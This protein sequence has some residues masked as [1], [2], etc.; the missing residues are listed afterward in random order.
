MPQTSVPA[1]MVIGTE[2]ALADLWTEENGVVESGVSEEATAEIAFGLAV[3]RG[4]ADDGV[5][6]LTAITES[7]RGVVVHSH[8]Y[9]KPDEL[10][11]TGLKTKVSLDL[12][13]FGQIWVIAETNVTPAS[14]VFIRAVATGS[15]RAGAF[16]GTA[17]GT[18]TI[19]ASA[20]FSWK[21]TTTA[22]DPALLEV[23][24]IG[25]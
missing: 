4:T 9:S 20:F 24:L 3:K 1:N 10:G 16:R 18:D 14:G 12:L 11:D 5:L 15:E 19:D 17:D 6:L 2:G 23:N 13:R 8:L 25:A 7:I 21:S 22:G